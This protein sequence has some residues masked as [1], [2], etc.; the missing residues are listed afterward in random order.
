MNACSNLYK[1]NL[2]KNLKFYFEVIEEDAIFYLDVFYRKNIYL[3]KEN[4]INYYVKELN[5]YNI[6]IYALKENMDELIY[7]NIFNKTLKNISNELMKDY[8]INKLNSTF[9]AFY[10][11]KISEIYILLEKYYKKMIKLY[12]E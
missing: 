2:L 3:F 11:N 9:L 5:E 6:E 4:Y 12:Q 8:I 7:D 10:N 1:K